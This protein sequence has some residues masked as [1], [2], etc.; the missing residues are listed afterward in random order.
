MRRGRR[1]KRWKGR[2]FERLF[3]AVDSRQVG[4]QAS[5]PPEK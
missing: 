4:R 3:R 1:E 2:L 5:L